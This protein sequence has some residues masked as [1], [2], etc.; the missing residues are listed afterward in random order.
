MVNFC[1]WV[2]LKIRKLGG[3]QSVGNAYWFESLLS[4]G[5]VWIF[6]WGEGRQMLGSLHSRK[7]ITTC[8][9]S[10]FQHASMKSQL[11]LVPV[12]SV[13]SSRVWDTS[14]HLPPMPVWAFVW[15]VIYFSC[16]LLSWLPPEPAHHSLVPGLKYWNASMLWC[17][18][19]LL[20]ALLLEISMN[21]RFCSHMSWELHKLSLSEKSPQCC[22]QP[23]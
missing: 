20:H 10:N 4:A 23:C 6:L 5:T 13:L 18:L 7:A 12:I 8:C 16:S 11:L 14:S 3:F 17:I 1:I 19:S 21:N 15:K 22:A 2:W 9:I